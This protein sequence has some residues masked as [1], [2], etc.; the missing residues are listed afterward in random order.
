M[1]AKAAS[2]LPMPQ[3]AE[4][5]QHGAPLATLSQTSSASFSRGTWRRRGLRSSLEMPGRVTE[6]VKEELNWTVYTQR[7]EQ[8]GA[9]L[10][11]ES[12]TPSVSLS[13]GAWRRG[14]CRRVSVSTAPTA[15]TVSARGRSAPGRT[16]S[17]MKARRASPTRCVLSSWV[18]AQPF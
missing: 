6:F 4:A 13:S 5:Q 12:Q 15:S 8:R 2:D 9:P 1:T 17:A 3:G 18:A 10:A 11:A 14:G 16:Y 7:Q